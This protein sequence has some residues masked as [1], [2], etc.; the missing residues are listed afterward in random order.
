VAGRDDED[1]VAS[2][3]AAEVLPRDADLS[4][5]DAVDGVLDAVPIG[6]A[7]STPALRDGGTAVFTRPPDPPEPERDLRF[8]TILVEPDQ[9]TLIR[10]AEQLAA[11]GLRTRVAEVL[12][13]EDAARG[14][15][16]AEAGG[17]RGKVVLRP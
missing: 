10:L 4:A 1:W 3:G 6:P 17:L 7:A 11:G 12:P 14:H 13:L 2:L 15:S 9:P 8:E 16:L 5:I